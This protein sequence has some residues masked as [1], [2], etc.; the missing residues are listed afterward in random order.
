MKKHLKKTFLTGLFILIPLVVTIYIIYTVVISV[1]TFISPVIRNIMSNITGTGVYIQGTGFFIFIILTYLT[2]VLAS[3]Y[4]GKKM[5]AYGEATIRKI[6]F[7]KGIYGSIKDM[8][9]AFSSEKM[10]SFK[11]VVLVD[12]PFKGR[13]AIGF[14]TK[15]IQS[16]DK[17]ELCAVFVPTTPNPTSGYLIFL[18]EEELTPIDMSVEDAVKY[19]VSLGTS[20]IEMKW[21][22]KKSSTC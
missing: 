19:I 11:E 22:E 9:D 21:K 4:I 3:N 5:L 16:G 14:I 13:Y 10:Q 2:G 18:P 15:R 1:D 17:G 7:V 20:R 12:F 8:I 6:P